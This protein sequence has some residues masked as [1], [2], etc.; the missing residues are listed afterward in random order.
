MRRFAGFAIPLL[1]TGCAT[2]MGGTAP[3]ATAEPLKVTTVVSGLTHPWDVGFL[4]DGRFL[5]P[6][7]P[8]RIALVD[9]GVA[10]TLT[11]DLSD[12]VARGEGGLMSLLVH[13]DFATSRQFTT[14]Y[15]TASDIRLVT[16]ELDGTTARKVKNPLLGGFPVNA[17]G[18]H[19]GCKLAVDKEGALLVGTGD[20]ANARAAQN[21]Q[22]LGGKV[23]RLN[24]KTGAA[25]TGTDRVY[26]YGHRNVQGIAVRS[27]GLVLTAEHGP[28]TDDEI[29]LHKPG[30][31]GW[32]PSKGGTQDRY[33]ESVPMTDTRR[34]PDAVPAV[35]SSG[36]PTEAISAAAF[37]SGP[38]WKTLDGWL[39]VTALRG[40][41]LLLFSVA[42]DGKVANRTVPPELS[43]KFGRLRA[44]VQ[45]PDG[46]LYLST[47]NGTDDKIL[48]VT[49]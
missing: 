11:A 14:C 20:T 4:P 32:D 13:P 44:A 25:F 24:L 26:S 39:A 38:Q 33:D 27:D 8:G 36:R 22:S 30:N 15:N 1:L 29:N 2:A 21:R 48:K 18:R 43:T 17:S 9:K 35:W 49:L 40:T 6:Q 23:L 47:S 12:V 19:S 16:W 10:T 28:S 7:R 3:A 41:K 5:V 46:A 45:G 34:F 37:L 42:K 31:F